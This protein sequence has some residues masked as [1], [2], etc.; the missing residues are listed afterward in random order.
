MKNQIKMRELRTLKVGDSICDMHYGAPEVTCED[1]GIYLPTR[2]KVTVEVAESLIHSTLPRMYLNKMLV[3]V[4][5]TDCGMLTAAY[6]YDGRDAGL[7]FFDL[8]RE[9]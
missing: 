4:C 9:D 7:V 3:V 8:D 6:T 1:G 2:R 5:R